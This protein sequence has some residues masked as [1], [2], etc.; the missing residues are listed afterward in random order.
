MKRL[1]AAAALAALCSCRPKPA[2]TTAAPEAAFA[3]PAGRR[4]FSLAIDKS[5]T[6][7]L[8]PG[9]A[10]EVAVLVDTPR[11]DGTRETRSEVLAPSAEVLRVEPSWSD[12]D[13]LA[14]V[15]LTP[16]Q[17]EFAALAVQRQDRLFLNKVA[18]TASLAAAPATGKPDLAPGM[19][20]LAIL[21]Y[22]DQEEFV[23]PGMRVDVI[24]TRQGGKAGGKAETSA[25]VLL[26]NVT[27][28]GSAPAQG[29]EEWAT[30]QLMLTPEQAQTLTRAVAAE[31]DL[32]LAVRADAD[33][34]TAPVEPARMSRKF[35]TEAER[36]SPKS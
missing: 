19:R 26:Q 28:I 27:V 8:S 6:K 34:A 11:A 31:D 25:L 33:A 23:D 35:G 4:G 7:F 3:P 16:E 29:N 20:G 36:G 14:Q 17:A 5:Q 21:V 18:G 2:E 13:G 1:L 15:A 12:E 10:V 24:A 9:D 22:P 30:V 32:T